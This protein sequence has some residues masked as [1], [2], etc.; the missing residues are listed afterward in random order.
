[1][2]ENITA[3]S[4]NRICRINDN[5]AIVQTFNNGLN[6]PRLRIIWMN[7]Q[8]HNSNVRKSFERLAAINK[9][10]RDFYRI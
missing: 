4:I 6:I 1:M 5:A 10:D 2:F 9:L 7:V 3:Q 8:K